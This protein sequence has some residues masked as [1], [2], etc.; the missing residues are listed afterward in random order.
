VLPLKT[1]TDL[2]RIYE[3]DENPYQ[4]TSWVRTGRWKVAK[5]TEGDEDVAL[6]GTYTSEA[7]ALE[8]IRARLDGQPAGSAPERYELL[9]HWVSEQGA[10]TWPQFRDA[11]DWLFN[12]GQQEG[13]QVKAT[14]TIH[15]L[16]VLGHLEIDWDSGEW[17]VAP[18][19]VTILP[20]AGA[21]AIL[22]GSRTRALLDSFATATSEG[23][24]YSEAYAQEWGPNALFVAAKNED[25]IE[26]LARTLGV[27]YEV[28]VS[29]R[30]AAVLLPLD[31]YLE[32][33]RSTPAARGYGVERFDP[34][35]LMFRRADTESGPGLYRYDMWGRPEFRFV[36]DDGVYYKLD[37][38]L[39][40]HAELRRCCKREIRYTPDSVNG[41]L[42]VP[43]RAQLPAL[44]ARTAVLCSGLMPKLDNW[45]W[46]YPNVPLDTATAIA[47][48]LGQEL[49]VESARRAP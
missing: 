28:C 24:L 34:R 13:R 26:S 37:W 15:G 49:I 10:G 27:S 33:C 30:L 38:A 22:C 8:A 9:L 4:V 46:H 45:K 23:D 2:V 14:T 48:A 47:Q 32:L 44:H 39:G 40:V 41:T 29:E 20:N 11:H 21:H 25:A 16:S 12:S 18:T 7:E 43:F 42:T 1:Q 19:T 6:V 3:D 31:S 5:R 35:L 17:A 36:A